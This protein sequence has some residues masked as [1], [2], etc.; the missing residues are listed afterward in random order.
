MRNSKKQGEQGS[1]CGPDVKF[2]DFSMTFLNYTRALSF[3]PSWFVNAA[4]QLSRKCSKI[5]SKFPH[6]LQPKKTSWKTNK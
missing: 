1:H 5:S 6:F 4:L 3:I 2:H